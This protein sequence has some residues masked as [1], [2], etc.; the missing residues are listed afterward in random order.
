MVLGRFGRGVGFFGKAGF[1]Q[2]VVVA[3]APVLGLASASTFVL[4][5][6]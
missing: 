4:A 1:W 6:D 2:V 3:L 5:A